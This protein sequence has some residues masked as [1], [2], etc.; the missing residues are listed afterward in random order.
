MEFIAQTAPDL[1]SNSNQTKGTAKETGA[2]VP[3]IPR[4]SAWSTNGQDAKSGGHFMELHGG[5]TIDTLV[6]HKAVA[7]VSCRRGWLLWI[8]DGRAKP[9]MDLSIYISIY[10]PIYLSTLVS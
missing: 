3:R 9:L 4:S 5:P 2:P 7:E 8:M 6:P 1:S 10:L